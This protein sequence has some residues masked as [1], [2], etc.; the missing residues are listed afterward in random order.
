MIGFSPQRI[1]KFL[2]ILVF[3]LP[4][5][6]ALYKIYSTKVN[7]FG[8]FDDCFNFIG[9]YFMLKGKV[10]Y[11]EIYFNH[12]PFMAF[13]SYF[14]Q[15]TSHPVNIYE[16]V[17]KHRQFVFLLGFLMNFLIIWRLGFI[18]AGFVLL[19]EFSKFYVFGDRF[20]AEGIIV[21]PIVYMT[22]LVLYK[23]QK[24]S[25]YSYDYILSAFFS[26][27]IIFMREPQLITGIILYGLI[28]IG[29]SVNKIKIASVITFIVLTSLTLFVFLP[30]KDYV[31]DVY[32]LNFKQITYENNVNGIFG[33]GFFKMF[34]YP[35][36]LFFGGNWNILRYYLTGL[37]IIFF[38]SILFFVKSSFKN[39]KLIVLIII[40][41]GLR[42][43][44]IVPP[45]TI[46]YE[47][48]N[49]S[50]W[51][52]S[53]IL[54]ILFIIRQ[55]FVSQKKIAIF[56][57]ILLFLLFF[58]ITL[59]PNSFTK[60]KIG[61]QEEFITNYG[62]YLQ[63]GEVVRILSKPDD[64]LFTDGADELIYWQS[65]R[66]SPYK[67][68]FYYS[69]PNFNK[70]SNARSEMFLKNPPDFYYDFCTKQN[71]LYPSIPD[72]RKKDYQQLYSDGK[73]TCLH[74]K[75]SKIPQISKDQ[76]KKAK[77][78]RYTLSEK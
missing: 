42:N 51:L 62:N 70:F 56:L 22:G 59:S 17:L 21:Y 10:L 47:A 30:F 72:F 49:L 41:L 61:M 7:A 55:I 78:F 23:F 5:Y 12:Q 65:D 37:S 48:F 27:F 54:V 19:Y 73:P 24:K 46:F 32:T 44:R 36:Y 9:G 76:W 50:P 26:W 29:K 53:Y 75:K 34:F 35:V 38:I 2:L 16:L 25:I 31:F 33:I 3:L 63:I 1:F 4:V 13:I 6:F 69:N 14:V 18:G 66:I 40:L 68:S 77:A 15:L 57:S 74:V 39:V 58:Y 43:F 64:T 11:S 8:C 20:L 71:I 45:G 60:Q 67:Y 52:S 28:L